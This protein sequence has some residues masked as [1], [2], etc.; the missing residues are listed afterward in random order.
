MASYINKG[1]EAFASAL[2]SEYVDKTGMIAEINKNLFTER[3]FSCVSR[4][5]RFGKSMAAQMLCAYYDK[6]CDSRELFRGL[7]IENH[8]DFEKH[9]NK[10]PVIY[11]DMTNF[12]TD[13][14]HDNRIVEHLQESLIES[15]R[16]AYPEV[17]LSNVS[18]LIDVLIDIASATGVRFIMIIDEWDAICREFE[19]GEQAMD[20]YVKLLRRMFKSADAVDVFAGVYMTGIFPIKKYNTESALNN[21]REYSMVSP[22]GLAKYLGFTKNEVKMLCGKYDMSYEEMEKWYDGY[23]LGS[24]LSMFNPNS[25]MEALDSK[26]CHSYWSATGAFDAVARYIQM[27][28]EG[29][30]GDIVQMLG[31]GRCSVKTTRFNNDPHQVLSKD[32][33]LTILIHLG[34]LAY[35]EETNTCYIP[36]KEV[37]GEMEAAI[38]KN[39]W[40]EV[41]DAINDSE[42]LLENLLEGNSEA[43]AA[44]V[45]KVHE[46]S[47]SV[48]QYN[49]ENALSCVINL[50]FYS[51]RNKYKIVRELPSGK[52]FADVVLIPWRNVN[53]PA[54]VVELKWKQDAQTALNQIRERNYPASLK[55]YIGEVIL[56]GI[57]YDPKSKNHSCVIEKI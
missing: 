50:A 52:G 13:Y 23:C 2:R 15:V 51:A 49:N 46:D 14:G 41:V 55:E 34:Y 7:E 45:E 54:I 43:V 36:N 28:Y 47:T 16:K 32:D 38:E 1:N 37:A 21:F 4:C 27:D 5:R 24:E 26:K 8:P 33:A 40:R 30:K 20:E 57:N 29:L 53:L 19:R 18:R 9:L 12:I 11:V 39:K 42:N 35:D 48:L 22:K 25:V 10:Y 3:R 6:S 56:C 44:G 31:G 17:A